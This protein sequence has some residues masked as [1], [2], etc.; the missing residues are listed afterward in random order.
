M[1]DPLYFANRM[2]YSAVYYSNIDNDDRCWI[3][4][5]KSAS[6]TPFYWLDGNN[7]TFRT[8]GSYEPDNDQCVFSNNGRFYDISCSA[9]Y[10]YICKG[11]YF[12]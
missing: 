11:I 5:Y 3:G 7:S 12:F 9:T 8:W 2:R 1:K 6:G 4:L 10:R